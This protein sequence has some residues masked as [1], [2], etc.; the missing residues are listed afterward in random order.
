VG[1]LARESDEVLGAFLR[2]QMLVMLALGAD[3]CG[4]PVAGGPEAGPADRR[5]RRPDQFRALPGRPPAIV[6]FGGDRRA[7]A[8]AG[9]LVAGR[10]GGVV[11]T[12]GQLLEELLC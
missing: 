11:F 1:R 2:G 12:V 4:R 10:R 6:L 7:G 3:L 8:G 9:R 5:H